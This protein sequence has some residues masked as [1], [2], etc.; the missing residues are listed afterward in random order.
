M[1]I[2]RDERF[3]CDRI[4]D[5]YF[6]IIE[7]KGFASRRVAESIVGRTEQRILRWG[8]DVQLYT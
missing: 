8:S 3:S 6:I 7:L 5:L 2:I 4:C 1:I